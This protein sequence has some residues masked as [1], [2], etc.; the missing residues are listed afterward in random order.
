MYFEWEMTATGNTVSSGDDKNV[1]ELDYGD[2]CTKAVK[3]LK[4]LSTHFNWV[5]CMICELCINKM[6]ERG[7]RP[8]RRGNIHLAD[9]L[10]CTAE[11]S[12][13]V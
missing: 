6:T 3:I 5:N 9:S 1:P 8:K 12:T 7:G 4:M 11:T 13:R 10:C 2:C